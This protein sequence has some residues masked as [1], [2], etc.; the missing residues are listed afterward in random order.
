MFS[1]ECHLIFIS[2]LSGALQALTAQTAEEAERRLAYCEHLRQRII[3]P[4]ERHLKDHKQCK[5]QNKEEMNRIHRI[6]QSEYDLVGKYRER[7]YSRCKETAVIADTLAMGIPSSGS[8][9]LLM[10]TFSEDSSSLASSSSSANERKLKKARE[11][12]SAADADFKQHMYKLIEING[13]WVQRVAESAREFQALEEA[14]LRLSQQA[15]QEHCEGL[16][17][18]DSTNCIV[19]CLNDD[20]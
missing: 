12:E 11:A 13:Q 14:R 10:Q 2:E 6:K 1:K 8:S 17:R 4:L 7:Y 5:R 16:L 20:Y 3:W 19:Q 9:S 18:L 15:L